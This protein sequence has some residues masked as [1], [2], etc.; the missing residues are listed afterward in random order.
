[1]IALMVGHDAA[2]TIT[3]Q[4]DADIRTVVDDSLAQFLWLRGTIAVIDVQ[5]VRFGADHV[6][7]G[8][9]LTKHT[10]RDVIGSAMGTVQ[11]QA[12]TAEGTIAQ[13]GRG[14]AEF[15]IPSGRRIQS[16]G[17]TQGMRRGAGQWLLEYG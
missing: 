10:G 17:A 1:E 2:I 4:R 3:V 8:A 13:P 5:S 9:Q 7:M 11:H 15:N 6:D 12:Q 16:L 14:F